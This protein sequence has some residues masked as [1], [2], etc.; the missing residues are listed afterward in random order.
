MAHEEPQPGHPLCP[1]D[2]VA[3]RD[4]IIDPGTGMSNFPLIVYYHGGAFSKLFH[5]Y[6]ATL[7][8]WAGTPS[9][10]E[11]PIPEMLWSAYSGGHT[12]LGVR[13][14]CGAAAPTCSAPRA[15]RSGDHY[16]SPATT[17]CMNVLLACRTNVRPR[18]KPEPNG[19]KA[20]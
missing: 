3:T 14:K 4:V 19:A 1:S 10:P 18:T 17:T 20:P 2:G 8:S 12:Q 6:A 13:A 11:H 7:S 16:L 15:A 9:S 5:R